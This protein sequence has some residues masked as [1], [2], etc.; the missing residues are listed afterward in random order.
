MFKFQVD[1]LFRQRVMDYQDNTIRKAVRPV[2]QI[3]LQL[4][5]DYFNCMQNSVTLYLDSRGKAP[6][7][8]INQVMVY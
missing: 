1:I 5:N 4:F 2:S 7:Y 8:I 6:H 3:Q